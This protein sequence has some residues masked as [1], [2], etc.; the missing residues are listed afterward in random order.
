MFNFGYTNKSTKI[1]FQVDQGSELAGEFRKLC[2]SEQ[3][4]N[5][6]TT[7]ETKDPFAELTILSLNNV[8]QRY[9]DDYGYKHTHKLAQFFITL[10]TKGSYWLDV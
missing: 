3:K 4:E 10:G 7:N 5:Q 8:F 1:F 6:T 2:E 9:M